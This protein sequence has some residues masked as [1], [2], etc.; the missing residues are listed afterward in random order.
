MYGCTCTHAERRWGEGA[1]VVGMANDEHVLLLV[2][3]VLELLHGL[4]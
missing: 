3:I 1:A 2:C 4:L